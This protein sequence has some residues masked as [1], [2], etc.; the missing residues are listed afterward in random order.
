M[1]R[2][3]ETAFALTCIL[4]MATGFMA[5]GDDTT[6]TD[7]YRY[8]VK[9]ASSML[10]YDYTEY[11]AVQAAFD[12]A[13]G[14]EGGKVNKVYSSPQDD[15]MKA[16]CEA[17]KN[18]YANIKSMYMKFNLY[19]IKS[20]TDPTVPDTGDLIATYELGQATIVPYMEYAFTSNGKEAYEAIKAKKGTV[21]DKVYN[22][23]VKTFQRLV[24]IHSSY[25]GTDLNGTTSA[26]ENHFRS[27]FSRPWPDDANYDRYVVYACDSI[28]NAH[29]ADTLIVDIKLSAIKTGF[30]DKKVS[31]IWEKTFRANF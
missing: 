24:G 9:I 19:R 6:N 28:Y 4:V 8:S 16:K 12:V 25:D 21:E 26:F 20:N 27:E 29:A 18:Q 10:Y 5:C 3:L 13:V 31:T 7:S 15:A 2:I 23:S 11:N 22:A 1:K 30:L 14:D 17:V